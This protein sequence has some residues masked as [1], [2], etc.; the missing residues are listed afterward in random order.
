[1]SLLF[2]CLC[3]PSC[4]VQPKLLYCNS[5]VK[6]SIHLITCSFFCIARFPVN[7]VGSAQ[8]FLRSYTEGK[9][10]TKSISESLPKKRIGLQRPL[11]YPMEEVRYL[12]FLVYFLH[13]TSVLWIIGH[14]SLRISYKSTLCWKNF[15]TIQCHL[16]HYCSMFLTHCRTEM[17][18]SCIKASVHVADN[19]KVILCYVLLYFCWLFG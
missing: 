17:L 16:R 12:L 15:G 4:W 5:V 19:V 3:L 13:L 10:N 1:V 2:L 14:N 6:H 18:F 8:G 9:L 7:C 11:Q